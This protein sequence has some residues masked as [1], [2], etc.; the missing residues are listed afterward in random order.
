MITVRALT[1]TYTG[2]AAP[3]I[4]ESQFHAC[5]GRVSLRWPTL[6]RVVLRPGMLQ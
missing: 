4:I 1:F 3:A 5:V 2:M 6:G